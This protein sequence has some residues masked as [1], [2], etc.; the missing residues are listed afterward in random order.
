[1]TLDELDAANLLDAVTALTKQIGSIRGAGPCP[2]FT[3]E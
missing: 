1:V 2:E 3:A